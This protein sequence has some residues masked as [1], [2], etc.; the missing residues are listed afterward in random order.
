M[1]VTRVTVRKHTGIIMLHRTALQISTRALE[2]GFVFLS[3]SLPT[4]AAQGVLPPI[5]MSHGPLALTGMAI[6][7]ASSSPQMRANTL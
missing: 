4:C 1:A 7:H 3:D 5:S 2:P 6:Y